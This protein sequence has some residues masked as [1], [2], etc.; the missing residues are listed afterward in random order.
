MKKVLGVALSFLT[1]TTG[2]LFT[3]NAT[4]SPSGTVLLSTELHDENIILI[5]VT[6]LERNEFSTLDT[7]A[8]NNMKWAVGWAQDQ[9]VI[10]LNSKDIGIYAWEFDNHTFQDMEINSDI[11][12][13]AENLF[14]QKYPHN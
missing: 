3:E 14:E 10:I 8:S 1:L 9:D 11:Q 12:K 13:Q 5:T 7:R 4:L 6:E 2:C